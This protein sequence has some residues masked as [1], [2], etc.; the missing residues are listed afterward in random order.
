MEKMLITGGSGKVGSYFCW[1]ARKGGREVLSTYY[2]YPAEM[3][4]IN[5]Q[6]L[7]LFEEAAIIRLLKEIK[8]DLVI[9]AAAIPKED[10]RERLI[11]V[12]VKATESIASYCA[13]AGIYMAYISTDLVFDGKKGYYS[14]EDR[15]SPVG[16]YAMSKV[17]GEEKVKERAFPSAI[18]RIPINYGWTWSRSTF[19]EWILGELQEG[20]QIKLFSDQQRSIAYLG[21]LAQAILEIVERRL[22]GIY[23]IGGKE[24]C[25]RYAFG[26][27]AARALGFSTDQLM[28]VRMKDIE[29]KG[30]RCP[31]C[32]LNITKARK[33][34]CTP[35][36][37]VREGL[38]ALAQEGGG[39]AGRWFRA[40]V[41]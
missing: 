4:G 32:S 17:L 16:E 20:R 27:E 36:L 35:L 6:R 13:G 40:A 31:N 5:Y 22:T 38:Q 14:E 37:S 1:H 8:P 29:Y 26:L 3:E 2:T 12:N 39:P 28:S 15:V 9:H 24:P 30:S 18:I 34:L 33:T 21:N 11:A 7:S 10:L 23:H 19:L 41:G 25:S